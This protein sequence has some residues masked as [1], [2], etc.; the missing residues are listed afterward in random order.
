MQ[1][2]L[3]RLRTKAPFD[4]NKLY[5]SEILSILLQ[6]STENKTLL[7]TMEGIDVLLQQLAVSYNN[8]FYRPSI[9]LP[10]YI[11]YSFFRTAPWGRLWSS[12]HPSIFC[13]L[14]H[15]FLIRIILRSSSKFCIHFS[16]GLLYFVF[17][18]ILR[19]HATTSFIFFSHPS[20]RR[21]QARLAAKFDLLYTNI[22]IN[23]SI[24]I[25]FY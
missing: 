17:L 18:S 10:H 8:F 3:K 19:S 13:T 21:D 7:G 5:I 14:S 1:W 15:Y 11:T 9:L 12:S 24:Q 23:I 20:V 4:P 6:N 25:L 16:L 22:I 2:L